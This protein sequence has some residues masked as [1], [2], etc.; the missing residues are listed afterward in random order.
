M[1]T[2]KPTVAEIKRLLREKGVG[3]GKP[4]GPGSPPAV[5]KPAQSVA[6]S[7]ASA[8]KKP[9]QS[10]ATSVASA[11]K[12][13]AQ[14]VATSVASAVKKP[15]ENVVKPTAMGQ[16]AKTTPAAATEAATA[17]QPAATETPADKQAKALLALTEARQGLPKDG[18]ATD[19]QV[20]ALHAAVLAYQQTAA[21]VDEIAEEALPDVADAVQALLTCLRGGTLVTVRW[22]DGRPDRTSLI[23]LLDWA[24]QIFIGDPGPQARDRFGDRMVAWIEASPMTSAGFAADPPA[25]VDST[26]RDGWKRTL[27]AFLDALVRAY[28]PLA[29]PAAERVLA[30]LRRTLLT[31]DGHVSPG[32]RRIDDGRLRARYRYVVAELATP[33]TARTRLCTATPPTPILP[34]DADEVDPKRPVDWAFVPAAERGAVAHVVALLTSGT[35]ANRL[36]NVV[37]PFTVP[38]RAGS[39]VAAVRYELVFDADALLVRPERLGDAVPRPAPGQSGAFQPTVLNGDTDWEPAEVEQLLAAFRRLPLWVCQRLA[40]TVFV[41]DHQHPTE[42]EKYAGEAHIGPP[43]NCSKTQLNVPHVHY[44]DMAFTR[45]GATGAPGDAGPGSAATHLHEVGHLHVLRPAWVTIGAVNRARDTHAAADTALRARLKDLKGIVA[46]H[47]LVVNVIDAID[48]MASA[49]EADGDRQRGLL[50]AIEGALAGTPDPAPFK[51]TRTRLND[52]RERAAQ[53]RANQLT[54]PGEALDKAVAA[55]RDPEVKADAE[56]LR[57]ADSAVEALRQERTVNV[58]IWA[59]GWTLFTFA[60]V[61]HGCGFVPFT[62]YAK[63]NYDE[64]LAETHFLWLTDPDRLYELSPKVFA[65]FEGGMKDIR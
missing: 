35:P 31:V 11:V 17:T 27:T 39:P 26:V 12:K 3:S 62:R 58:G 30:G 59:G 49:L 60:Q 24:L 51:Q 34:P 32:V 13:P 8:V 43:A 44:Y 2:P 63:K 64:W 7:V 22:P 23:K 48:A 9:A 52:A 16:A 50:H 21:T 36:R 40:E 57:L 42:P 61:A 38:M 14:S 29:D 41:R 25:R 53:E 6:T 1:E 20:Q 28:I 56:L 65:W 33:G 46:V 19:A 18:P 4:P 5:K 10:V 47:N 37:W 55:L 15:A 45:Q 54:G